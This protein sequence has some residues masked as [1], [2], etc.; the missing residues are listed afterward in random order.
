MDLLSY[1]DI[2]GQKN[3]KNVKAI[4]AIV[5]LFSSLKNSVIKRKLDGSIEGEEQISLQTLNDILTNR[6]VPIVRPVLDT[7][8]IIM[9]ELPSESDMD[10][11]DVLI[12]NLGDVIK[13]SDE[14]LRTLGDIPP[15]EDGIGMPRWFQALNNYFQ[16]YPLGDYYPSLGYSFKEDGEYFR[17]EFPGSENLEG[18]NGDNYEGNFPKDFISKIKQSLRRGHGPTE[19]GLVKGGTEIVIPSDK[20]PLK[21]YVIFP[22]RAVISGYIGAIRTG[23]L[24]DIILRSMR[25]Y[26]MDIGDKNSESTKLSNDTIIKTRAIWMS[27]ILENLGGISDIRDAQNILY[28]DSSNPSLVNIPFSVYLEMILKTIVIGGPGDLIRI[29]SDLGISEIELT[30]EQEEIFLKRVG[31]IIQ[32][33][34]TMIRQIREKPLSTTPPTL[35]NILDNKYIDE[36]AELFEGEKN[37]NVLYNKIQKLLPGYKNIDLATFGYLFKYNQD[38]LL[39]CLSK[40]TLSSKRERI[41]F[42]YNEILT[43]LHNKNQE[44]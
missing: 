17:G 24:W 25:E 9:S 36:I 15:G 32:S 2:T 40:N 19:R 26:S 39:A 13:Q 41:L 11:D 42:N 29:K 10:L 21:G 43:I 4:R 30:I 33:V 31:E 6:N 12:R 38:Y 27:K 3:P 18:L 14:Y 5:E 44:R 16:K 37:L 23:T 22:Y 35:Q 1:L 28:L 8:R 34:R 20:A 7:K